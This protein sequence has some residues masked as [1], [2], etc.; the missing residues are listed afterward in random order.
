MPAPPR[1]DFCV[2]AHPIGGKVHTVPA[3][4]VSDHA[5][6]YAEMLIAQFPIILQVNSMRDMVRFAREKAVNT[7]GIMHGQKGDWATCKA[8]L[9][10]WEEFKRRFPADRYPRGT[11]L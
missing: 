2:Q 7:G 1:C 4:D 8:H 6:A 3:K 9:R 5:R 11:E 10:V